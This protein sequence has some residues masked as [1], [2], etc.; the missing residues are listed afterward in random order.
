M[1]AAAALCLAPGKLVS[2]ASQQTPHK[3]QLGVCSFAAWCSGFEAWL[4]RQTTGPQ[5]MSPLSLQQEKWKTDKQTPQNQMENPP[6][7]RINP[8]TR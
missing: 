2:A 4:Q 6:P 7:K 8:H 3:E 1:T 5:L